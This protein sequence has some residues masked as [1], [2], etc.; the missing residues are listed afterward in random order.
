M[1]EKEI[2]EDGG[3]DAPASWKD[4]LKLRDELRQRDVYAF[5]E[6]VSAIGGFSK[7]GS[8]VLAGHALKGA[9]KSGWLD[10]EAAEVLTTADGKERFELAGEDVDD[11]HPG[12]VRWY[13]MRIMALYTKWVTPPPN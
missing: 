6:N 3:S 13:G 4:N 10:A 7:D 9:I 5:E 11:M 12:K 8:N 2:R 1:S